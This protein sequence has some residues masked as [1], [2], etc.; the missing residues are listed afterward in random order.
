MIEAQAD[1]HLSV[2]DWQQQHH[3][4][5]KQDC[6]GCTAL[7]AHAS[8]CF[9]LLHPVFSCLVFDRLPLAVG[10]ESRAAVLS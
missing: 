5:R 4:R 1:P 8:C 2:R 9:I 6:A 10:P 7:S 3:D